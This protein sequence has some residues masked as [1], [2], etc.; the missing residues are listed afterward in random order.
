MGSLRKR[1]GVWW[2]R[3]Y[4]H[5]R[6]SEESAHTDNKKSAQD[7][8]K[9]REGDVAKGVPISAKIGQFRFEDA[10]TD[11]INDYTVN[12]GSDVK[13][14]VRLMLKMGHDKGIIP[15]KVT[16]EFV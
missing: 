15:H 1:G 13:K 8:L 5:G 4:R 9:I 11:I 10:A 12:M 6:R 16:P 2:I 7:L 14:A 3:Y